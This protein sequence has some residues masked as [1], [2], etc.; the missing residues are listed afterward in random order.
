MNAR[1]PNSSPS[2]DSPTP[3]G[4]VG[5]S[6]D[7]GPPEIVRIGLV[8]TNRTN[9]SPIRQRA[10]STPALVH[11]RTRPET[12]FGAE[13]SAVETPSPQTPS[14]TRAD[15]S[16]LEALR[17]VLRALEARRARRKAVRLQGGTGGKRC[18]SCPT[19]EQGPVLGELARIKRK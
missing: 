9:G 16:A 1:R 13:V 18:A 6:D 14:R 4:V 15:V 5:R 2:P 11:K 19:C 10:E 12:A 3:I 7:Q 17:A 8:R